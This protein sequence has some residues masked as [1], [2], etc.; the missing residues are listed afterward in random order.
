MLFRSC[1]ICGSDRFYIHNALSKKCEDCGFVYYANPRA[2]TVALIR[3]AKGE[4][5]VA[6]RGK[7]PAKGTLDLPGGFVD[8][9]ETGEEAVAREVMEETGLKVDEVKYLFSLPNIYPYSG[10]VVHTLDQFYE[11]RINDM[12]QISAMD[13]VADLMW[14]APKEI[15]PELFGLTSINKGVKK[16]IDEFICEN[17]QG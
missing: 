13:D 8:N 16:Y 15:K 3:N 5:L 10:I 9:Y 6:R 11:C 4:I 2:A 1:P 14:I 17:N 7:E 12:S